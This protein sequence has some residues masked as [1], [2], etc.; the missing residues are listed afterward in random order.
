VSGFESGS[1]GISGI[2]TGFKSVGGRICGLPPQN[3]SSMMAA[4]FKQPVFTGNS[5][6]ALKGSPSRVQSPQISVAVRAPVFGG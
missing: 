5:A 6:A 1:G 3:L 4:D 2:V